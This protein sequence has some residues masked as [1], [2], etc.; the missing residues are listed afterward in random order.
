[1]SELSVQ[2]NFGVF[3]S[4][5]YGKNSFAIQKSDVSFSLD[6]SDDTFFKD[7]VINELKCFHIVVFV[8]ISHCAH[9]H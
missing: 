1:M 8:I 7:H 6:K 4:I 3:I 9:L 5:F 2:S